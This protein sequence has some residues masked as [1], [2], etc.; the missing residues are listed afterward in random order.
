MGHFD[1]FSVI[2]DQSSEQNAPKMRS[3]SLS[4]KPLLGHFGFETF[5]GLFKVGEYANNLLKFEQMPSF[6]YL[7][8]HD[9]PGSATSGSSQMER[10]EQV[11]FNFISE[12][13]CVS[14]G[15]SK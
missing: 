9:D 2:S 3:L 15:L 13:Q 14:G 4:V 5:L 12:A 7:Q 11:L 1:S 8:M 10:R 6:P